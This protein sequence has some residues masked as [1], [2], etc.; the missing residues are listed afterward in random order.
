MENS[1][2]HLNKYLQISFLI[3]CFA[4]IIYKNETLKYSFFLCI[5]I[6]NSFN[7]F[8]RTESLPGKQTG[9]G[10]ADISESVF[11][12]YTMYNYKN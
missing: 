5:K 2:F 7:V 9:G 8:L 3:I 10:E 12:V 4:I 1:L 11:H 6:A